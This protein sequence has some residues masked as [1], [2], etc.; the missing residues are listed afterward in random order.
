MRYYPSRSLLLH[1]QKTGLLRTKVLLNFEP[2]R[3]LSL[4]LGWIGMGLML[5]MNL[6]SLR[7]RVS[8]MDAT[9]SLAAWL[10]FHVFCG[11]LGPTFIF[12]HCDF[13]VR[14][15]VGISFWSMVI[16]FSSGIIGRYFYLQI[17]GKKVEFEKEV[18][19]WMMRLTK[20]FEKH[21]LTVE[22]TTRTKV[23]QHAL[24]DVGLKSENEDDY[25]PLSALMSS[26]KGD[27]KLYFSKPK[28]AK[29]W[30]PDSQRIVLG[31]AMSKRKAVLLQ[32]FLK[33]MGYWHAFHFPFAIFMYLVAV[34]HITAALFLGV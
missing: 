3:T 13:K 6:Y 31:Y 2:G 1:F 15:L 28:I 16:S 21:Q 8:F 32:P 23:L 34:I 30:P 26:L 10:N 7:K 22:E 24:R 19:Q 17:I 11:L 4:W 5:I 27:I 18:T 14:G 12:F 29:G 25:S 20:L 9:G 33:L